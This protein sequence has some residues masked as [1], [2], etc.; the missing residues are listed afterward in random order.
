MDPDGSH[1]DED[2]KWFAGSPVLGVNLSPMSVRFAGYEEGAQGLPGRQVAMLTR[3]LDRT[4][5]RLLFIPHVMGAPDNDDHAY[6]SRLLDEMPERLRPRVSLLPA[7]LGARRT[8]WI[9]SHCRALVAARMHCAVAGLSCAVPTLLVS[10]SRKAVGMCRYAYGTEDWVL[11][12]S[13]R[14]EDMAARVERLLESADGLR[15]HLAS[16]QPGFREDAF[17]GGRCLREIVAA[18]PVATE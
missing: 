2:G 9:V 17:R 18:E 15:A 8:K 16:R 5:L 14:G 12:V 10:Y 1:A 3:L 13:S 6:L 4:D 11:P 7:A